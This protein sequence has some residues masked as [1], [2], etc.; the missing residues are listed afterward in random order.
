[1]K[2][3]FLMLLTAAALSSCEDYLDVQPYGRTIPKTAEEFSALTHNLLNDIDNGESSM[4]PSISTVLS[5]DCGYGDDFEV[6]L[7]ESSGKMLPRY[8]GEVAGS[9]SATDYS[10]LYEYIRDC[11]VVI[12]NMKEEGSELADKVRAAVYAMRAVS[13]YNLLRLYCEAPV[14]GQ[15]DGQLGVAVVTKFDMEERP[16]RNT[17]LEVVQQIESDLQQSLSY[18]MNDDLY[19]FTQDVVKGYLA[20]LFFWTEQWEKVIPLCDELISRHPL[21]DTEAFV[22]MMKTSFALTGNQ[23]IKCNRQNTTLTY[24]RFTMAV[25]QMSYRPVS[26][27]F[28]GCFT[29]GEETTDVRYGLSVNAKRKVL[30][31]P[32]SGMRTAELV[33]MKAEAHAHLGQDS[34]ALAALN[35]LR[36]H[37]I[38]GYVPLTKDQLEGP[39]DAELV[40]VDCEGKPLTKLLATILRERR[41]ELFLECDRF[42]EMKRNGTPEFWVAYNGRKYTTLPYMYTL[43]IPETEIRINESVK[44]NPGYTEL[45]D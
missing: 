2:K 30:K 35:S 33:L 16:V 15:M 5:F 20:R 24:D 31:I 36:A 4:L 8:V 25:A 29:H 41:K 1:M 23:L 6:C 17:M 22:S 34:E 44:Q 10:K 3:I 38:K 13:Y 9:Y 18:G 40:R 19:R 32:F 7:T 11:N 43:P 42:F 37:R 12:D 27:R 39:L 21:L 14:S 45:T 28:L 26:A